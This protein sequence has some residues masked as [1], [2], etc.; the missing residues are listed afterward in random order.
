MVT[1]KGQSSWRK[2]RKIEATT[3]RTGVNSSETNGLYETNSVPSGDLIWIEGRLVPKPSN[4]QHVSHGVLLYRRKP[5]A[6][7]SHDNAAT[8]D[9]ANNSFEFLLGLIPQRNFWTVFKGMP[10]DNESPRE[11]AAREFLEETSVSLP[12]D[13]TAETTLWGKTSK[14]YLHISLVD[15]TAM[16]DPIDNFD[17]TKVTTIDQGYLEGQPEIVHIQWLNLSQAMDGVVALGKNND[18]NKSS[19]SVKIYPSQIGIIKHAQAF[20]SAKH[21]KKSASE[22]TCKEDED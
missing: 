18:K 3:T 7:S 16:S 13:W 19:K 8:D 20:L 21:N 6:P 5:D 11:T 15:G 14:K 17:I 1:I 22:I 2:R 12:D 10:N 4:A 9:D